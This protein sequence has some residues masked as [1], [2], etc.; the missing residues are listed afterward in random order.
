MTFAF[1]DIVFAI[2]ILAIAISATAKGFIAELFGKA[3]FILG[4]VIAGL[5]KKR[6]KENYFYCAEFV[7]YIL[8]K[9]NIDLSNLPDVI[10][11]ED[12]KNLK[13]ANVIY[14]GY[15]RDYEVEKINLISLIKTIASDKT[16]AV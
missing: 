12:F 4:L 16:I 9:G 13:N 14:K 11:P 1:I 6:N 3:A 10:K 5:N 2:I 15:L 8:D 7:K